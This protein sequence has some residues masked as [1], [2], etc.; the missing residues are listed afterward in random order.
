MR[1]IALFVLFALGKVTVLISHP[2]DWSGWVLLAYFWQDALVALTFA[3]V[4]QLLVRQGS[5]GRRF[6]WAM[7]WTIAI[8]AALNLVVVRAMFTPITLP[9]LR[10]AG[11]PL[12]DSFVLYATWT[13][14]LLILLALLILPLPRA[15]RRSSDL[16]VTPLRRPVLVCAFLGAAAL[17][18]LG[19]RAAARINTAGLDRNVL[20]ALI[21]SGLSHVSSHSVRADD[22]RLSPFEG[23][24]VEDLSG[25][26]GVAKSRNVVLVNL[27][28]A[29]AQYLPLYGGTPSLTPHLD[30]LA[31]DAVVFDSA[32]AA[33]PESIKGLFSM[34]CSVFPIFDSTPETYG[35]MPCRSLAAILVANG[36]RTGLFHSGRFGY[37][38]MHEVI[39]HRGFQTLEDAGH[40]GGIHDSSFGVDE[41]STVSRMLNWIDHERSGPFFLYYMPIA[42]H[43]PYETPGRGPLPGDEDID[44][45]RN[46]LHYS[47]AA[48]GALREGIRVR[49]LDQNTLWIVVGDH[50]EAFGQ[51]QGNYGH[52][53]FVYD[54]NVR[55]PLVLAAPGAIRDRTRARKVVSVVDIAPTVLD[56]LAL[57]SASEHQG[58][59]MLDATPRMA[60][61]FADYS[62]GLVGLR[63]TRWKFIHELGSERSTLFDL[64]RDPQELVDLSSLH[65][66]RARWYRQ[67]LL[68]WSAAQK[69]Y[70]RTQASAHPKGR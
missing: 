68:D 21:E 64:E 24:W 14:A 17:T 34:L 55:V 36:Y 22:W 57:P 43:H 30:A 40:I 8:Y 33:Y 23:E 62:L 10:A 44:R 4:D 2:P 65:V 25:L 48:L 35:R 37:L 19:P 13:N 50:G 60:M 66:D 20:T 58:R 9:M 12:A 27:E 49:G 45:Y 51:H 63:D 47:D 69:D 46:A 26:R 7:Y 54:E 16:V 28:S 59:S 3:G 1:A 41:P 52:T 6:V 70:V 11:A 42:G 29:A 32:Y 38:G 39:D 5:I 56:L 67:H 61:F 15:L 31:S 18:A 53:F